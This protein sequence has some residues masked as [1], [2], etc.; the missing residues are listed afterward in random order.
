MPS[1]FRPEQLSPL[2]RER[3]GVDQRRWAGSLLGAVVVAAFAAALA[4]VWLGLGADRVESRLLTWDDSQPGRVTMVVNVRRPAAAA[5]ICVLRAQDRTRVDVGYAVVP[6]PPGA[7][8]VTLT[9]QLAV[10]AP[11]FLAEVLGCSAQ[12]QPQVP[13]PQFPPG[14]PAPSQPW[15][16]PPATSATTAESAT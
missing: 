15:Q 10:V 14:V 11:A 13:E 3:Y 6:V 16:E 1:P 7:S 5:V 8:E 9:Y 12:G 4:W 2:M